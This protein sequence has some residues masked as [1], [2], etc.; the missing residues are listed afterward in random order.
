MALMQQVEALKQY[1]NNYALQFKNM[2]ESP[3][4]PSRITADQFLLF[5]KIGNIDLGALQKQIESDIRGQMSS[6]GNPSSNQ[7]QTSPQVSQQSQI[8][9]KNQEQKPQ[10]QNS[11]QVPISQHS[12]QNQAPQSA[13]VPQQVPPT[14][15]EMQNSPQ[16]PI[17]QHS[18]Q[19]QAPQ[20][21]QL[22]QQVPPTSNGCSQPGSFKTCNVVANGILGGTFVGRRKRDLNAINKK[23]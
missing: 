15:N 23:D 7:P 10:K 22:P 20:S 16:V 1:Y 14:S 18:N 9:S 8:P 21:A 17:S 12:N 2:V 4:N 5:N 3:Q 19:I 6:Q 13:Q 11:P